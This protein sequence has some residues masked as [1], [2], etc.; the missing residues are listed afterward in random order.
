MQ[1]SQEANGT[2]GIAPLPTR[3][4]Q[5]G[6]QTNPEVQGQAAEIPGAVWQPAQLWSMNLKD[7]PGKQ[8]P[9]EKEALS[10]I[11]EAGTG[12]PEWFMPPG[13]E[14]PELSSPQVIHLS[15]RKISHSWRP[16]TDTDRLGISKGK[17]K[18]M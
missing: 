17:P 3:Y 9:L 13:E 15:T 5:V 7:L 14:T 18:R 2:K 11:T 10:R 16:E 6:V 12:Y 4:P 8:N 1:Q